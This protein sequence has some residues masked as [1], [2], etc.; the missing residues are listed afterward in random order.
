MM[1]RMI[2]AAGRLLFLANQ[3]SHLVAHLAEHPEVCLTFVHPDEELYVAI[4]GSAEIESDPAQIRPLWTWAYRIWH[5]LRWR[6]P[7]L[8]LLAVSVKDV[9]YWVAPSTLPTRLLRSFQRSLTHRPNNNATHGTL[10][11]DTPHAP[12]P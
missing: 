11:V 2:D 12:L 6:D 10:I 9:E 1:L 4:S 7:N 3:R 5:P 8:V